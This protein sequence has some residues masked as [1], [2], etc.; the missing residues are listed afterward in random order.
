MTSNPASQ[1]NCSVL[2]AYMTLPTLN[3]CGVKQEFRKTLPLSSAVYST[4][5]TLLH[6]ALPFEHNPLLTCYVKDLSSTL[7]HL[8][9]A[10]YLLTLLHVGIWTKYL[11]HSS[12]TSS[13]EKAEDASAIAPPAIIV[14]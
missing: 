9:W 11:Y 13:N 4:D 5:T 2:A 7:D 10:R 12:M 3:T 14:A 1:P 8:Y 6:H